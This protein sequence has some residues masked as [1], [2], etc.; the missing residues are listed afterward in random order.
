STH[1]FA[2]AH[3]AIQIGIIL[4]TGGVRTSP[5]VSILALQPIL[6][7]MMAGRWTGLA[8]TLIV[9]AI[10]IVLAPFDAPA[11]VPQL[12]PVPRE[13]VRQSVWILLCTA[14]FGCF[15]YVDTLNRR[16]AVRLGRERDVAEFAAAHDPL[17]Q[18]LNR[19][20]FEQRLATAVR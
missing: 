11:H 4:A 20:A 2:L 8:W 12:A 15:W 6:A 13:I 1:L 10:G 19:S 9:V 17:T 7:F 5:L 14:L 18:L 16:L 3:S